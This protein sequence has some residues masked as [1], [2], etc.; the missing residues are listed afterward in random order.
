MSSDP[1]AAPKSSLVETITRFWVTLVIILIILYVAILMISR[2]DGFRGVVRQRLE[3]LSGMNLSVD[4]VYAK[5]RLDLVV[6]GLRE[7]TNAAHAV[8]SFE[9]NRIE[10]AWRWV[11]LIR[12]EGWPFRRLHIQDGQMMFTQKP[13]KSW[14]PLPRL[15]PLVATWLDI[16]AALENA[17]EKLLATEWLRT[18]KADISLKNINLIWLSPVEEEPPLVLIEGLHLK[19]S[20]MRPFREPVMWFEMTVERAANLGVVWARNLHMEWI[21]LSDQDV[22]LRY[23]QVEEP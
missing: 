23:R 9:I 20:P 8:S 3:M 17:D 21:R 22:V 1:Q 15:H 2:T 13:D 4:R 11:P 16:P 5:P 12:G 6:E 7:A 10:F 18:M 19:T 14:T